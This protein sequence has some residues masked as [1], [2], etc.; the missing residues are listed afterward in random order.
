MFPGPLGASLTGRALAEGLWRLEPVQIRDVA[1]DR[2]RTVD[3]SPAGG[4]AGMVLKADIVAAALD[5][6]DPGLPRADW[7]AIYL[8]PRGAPLDPGPRPG[9]RGG[10]AASRCCAGGSRASTSG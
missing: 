2:H 6:A 9:A 3:D 1:T 10:A 8:S 7:P 5:A 4:G